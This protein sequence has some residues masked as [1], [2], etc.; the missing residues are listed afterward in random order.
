MDAG[1]ALKPVVGVVN[2]H[3]QPAVGAAPAAPPI[4]PVAKTVA[5][6][7]HADPARNQPRQAEKQTENKAASTTRD[8]IIDPQTR[9]IVYRVLDARTRRV[10][11]QVPDQA[12]LRMQA[13]TRA[14]AAR[15]LAEGENP[16]VAAQAAVH[17]VDALT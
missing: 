4:L 1:M 5:P 10:L 14:K 3:A 15:A 9:E 13:Y 12:M 8:T 17:K 11:H 7:K 2:N 16:V 6:A